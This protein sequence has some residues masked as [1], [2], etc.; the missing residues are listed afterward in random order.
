MHVVAVCLYVKC[1]EDKSPHMLIDFS[2]ALS[3]NV[4]TLGACF[5]KF[6][7]RPASL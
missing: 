6:M 7:Q 1:R 5:L 4:F 2:D 3:V